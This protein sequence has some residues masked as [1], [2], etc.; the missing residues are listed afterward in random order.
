[1]GKDV[2]TTLASTTGISIDALEDAG[3]ITKELWG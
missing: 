3:R 1:M 2:L